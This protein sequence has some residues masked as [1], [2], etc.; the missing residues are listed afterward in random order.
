MPF[1]RELESLMN[2]VPGALGAIVA[3]WE[4]EAVD[5]VARMDEYEL[6]IHGAH[7]GVILSNMREVMSRLSP[8]NLQEIVV[9]TEKMQTLVVPVTPDYF[10]VFALARTGNLGLALHAAHLCAEMLRHDI[11]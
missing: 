1:K 8:G 3:D 11:S 7:S 5:Q 2:R 4:G 9:T 6:K 10:L